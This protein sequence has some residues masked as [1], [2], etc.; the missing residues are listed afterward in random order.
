LSPNRILHAPCLEGAGVAKAR[1]NN[2]AARAP[3]KIFASGLS[4]G[5]DLGKVR[6]FCGLQLGLNFL[7]RETVVPAKV[8]VNCG[9]CRCE[10][11]D[12]LSNDRVETPLLLRKPIDPE[13]SFA[14]RRIL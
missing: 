4:G 1:Q 8:V 13:K 5:F 12:R 3:A 6:P 11:I 10:C 2:Q 14:R 9:Y 7:T